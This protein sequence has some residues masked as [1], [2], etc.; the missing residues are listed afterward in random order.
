MICL[1]RLNDVF[2]TGIEGTGI[3]SFM[4]TISPVPWGEDESIS[5]V[6]LDIEYFGNISGGKI[7][8]PIIDRIVTNETISNAEITKIANIIISMYYS[9]WIKLYNTLNLEYN[10]ISN[11]DM[12]EVMTN[13]ITATQYGKTTTRTDNLTH[14]KTGTETDVPNLTKNNSKEVFGFNSAAAVD[15]DNQSDVTTGSDQITYNTQ[16]SDTGTQA[17]VDSGSDTRTRNYRL[18]RSGNIGVTTTQQMIE[19]ER[20]IAIW[21]FFYKVVFPDVDRVMTIAIY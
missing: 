9:K 16:E 2:P 4:N 21:D 18:T 3:F 8:S 7:V 19:Q 15:T 5:N 1:K 11:Y 17:N 14:A 12:L 6:A 10:P 20:N 13:D